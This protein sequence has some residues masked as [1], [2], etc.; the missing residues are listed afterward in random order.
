MY[1]EAVLHDPEMHVLY[2]NRALCYRKLSKWSQCEADARTAIE[3]RRVQIKVCHC[4][5]AAVNATRGS[6]SCAAS[7]LFRTRA[8]WRHHGQGAGT[9]CLH[10]VHA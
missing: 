3:L 7:C 1:T 10:W 8:T 4:C 9:T 5:T 6:P 2:V